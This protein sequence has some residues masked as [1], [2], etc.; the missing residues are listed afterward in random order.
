MSLPFHDDPALVGRVHTGQDLDQGG[1][2]RA[3]LAEQAVHLTGQHLEV[4]ATQGDHA[5]EA[6]HDVG[7]HQQGRGAGA[8]GHGRKV[9]PLLHVASSK[10]LDQRAE[11]LSDVPEEVAPC[12]TTSVNSDERPRHGL[13][14]VRRRAT[15]CSSCATARHAP[16]PS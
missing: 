6:F 8:S 1:L 2:A 7:H 15:C 9:D 11:H 10:S 16:G 12:F 13:R 3:V 14:A 4:D 5:G